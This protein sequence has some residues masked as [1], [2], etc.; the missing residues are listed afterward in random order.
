MRFEH[1]RGAAIK[2]SKS[3]SFGATLKLRRPLLDDS[4]AD[5]RGGVVEYKLVATVSH[6]GRNAAGKLVATVSHHGR[7]AAGKLVAT[8]S[9][10]GRNAAGKLLVE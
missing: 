6:H 1:L 2:I 4:V 7:N 8:V 5:C 3:V 9:H 10:H